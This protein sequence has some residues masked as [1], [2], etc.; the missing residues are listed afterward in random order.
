MHPLMKERDIDIPKAT[1]F[2]SN[3][4]NHEEITV[5]SEI[6]YLLEIDSSSNSVDYS[7]L[8]FSSLKV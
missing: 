2:S 6:E 8:L 4:Y 7:F 3:L 5:K 1:E